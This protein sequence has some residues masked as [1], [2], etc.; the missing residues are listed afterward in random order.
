MFH[1]EEFGAFYGEF[2]SCGPDEDDV[3]TEREA[4]F[5][6]GADSHYAALLRDE[7]VIV[8]EEEGV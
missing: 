4:I 6:F 7:S 1:D 8:W 5:V 3:V 2:E